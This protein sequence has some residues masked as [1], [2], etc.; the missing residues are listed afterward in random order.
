L[1]TLKLDLVALLKIGKRYQRIVPRIEPQDPTLHE[2][3]RN[4]PHM[5]VL[6]SVPSPAELTTRPLP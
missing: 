3:P 5:I 6:H 4:Q 2:S 1:S